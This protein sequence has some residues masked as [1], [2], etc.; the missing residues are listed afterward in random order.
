MVNTNA[1]WFKRNCQTYQNIE[2]TFFTVLTGIAHWVQPLSIQSNG[3]ASKPAMDK[4]VH[5]DG[6]RAISF[7]PIDTIKTSSLWIWS[8]KNLSW[9]KRWKLR[10]FK[11]VAS[12]SSCWEKEKNKHQ[13]STLPLIAWNFQSLFRLTRCIHGTPFRFLFFVFGTITAFNRSFLC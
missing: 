7:P 6:A 10:W 3:R 12:T 9:A 13:I 8:R 5:G 1:L 11:V 4:I 2:T